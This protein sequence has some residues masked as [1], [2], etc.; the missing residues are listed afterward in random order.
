MNTT[1]SIAAALAVVLALIP[2]AGAQ[3]KG[4]SPAA[5]PKHDSA[6][7]ASGPKGGQSAASKAYA[8]AN[9]KMHRDMNITFTGNSDVDFVKGMIPHHQG[10]I[11]M[12]KVVLAHGKDPAI[13]KLA[14][15]IVKAQEAEIKMMREWL[16]KHEKK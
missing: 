9:A 10:A 5:Q 15:E 14:E 7:H 13:R 2:A 4:A 1:R 12:A 6:A 11:D 16:A 3:Q 8:A